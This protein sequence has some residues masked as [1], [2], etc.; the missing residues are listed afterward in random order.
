[1]KGW[2]WATSKFKS[3]VESPWR[4]ECNDR[5]F[6]AEE[7]YDQGTSETTEH[8]VGKCQVFCRFPISGTSSEMFMHF[9]VVHNPHNWS[10]CAYIQKIDR[11]RFIGMN[12]ET[13]LQLIQWI[14]CMHIIYVCT[15]TYVSFPMQRATAWGSSLLGPHLVALRWDC[16]TMSWCRSSVE[17]QRDPNKNK[18][19]MRDSFF[20]LL[21]RKRELVYIYIC[22]LSFFWSNHMIICYLFSVFD[23]LIF[24]NSRQSYVVVS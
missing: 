5:V 21:P 19:H 18:R 10:Y 15:G 24:Q 23:F 22:T 6:F 1:M 11:H 13:V 3:S 20:L 2:N 14:Y 8:V 12:P 4:E 7:L 16:P 17:T 9:Q